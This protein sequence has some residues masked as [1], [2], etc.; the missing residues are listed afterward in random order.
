MIMWRLA[1]Y[2]Q[3]HFD[4]DAPSKLD[5]TIDVGIRMSTILKPDDEVLPGV[6]W[7]RP[8]E[9]FTPAYWVCLAEKATEENGFSNFKGDLRCEVF[10]CLLGGFG[11]KAELNRAAFNSLSKAGLFK[12]R[13]CPT[14]H[15]IESLLRKPLNLSGR[16]VRY[17][18]PRQRAL[19]LS[20]AA[21]YL[22]TCAAPPVGDPTELRKWLLR[23][24][25]I[26]LKTASWIVRNH[27]GS[28]SVAILDVH[29]V[30]IGQ[31]M[32]LFERDIRLPKDY[33]RLER[34]FIEFAQAIGVRPSIL[35]A[36]MW[37]EVRSLG[38]LVAQYS[39]LGRKLV[40]LTLR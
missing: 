10:F 22:N 14:A 21:R 5:K 32:N 35:D 30:R 38:S 34:V 15:E 17:R 18:F 2:P 4:R 37:R 40:G 36:I 28:D 13:R 39:R 27:L 8:E 26:G 24:P 33:E 11:I 19:R 29:I 20:A 12:S 7:G 25:G 31:M 9:I 6:R 16:H 3:G 23:I 1:G